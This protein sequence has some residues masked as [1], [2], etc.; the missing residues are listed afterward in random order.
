MYCPERQHFSTEN[1]DSS[2]WGWAPGTTVCKLGK[3]LVQKV[4]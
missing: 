4:L 1:E 3:K 2:F